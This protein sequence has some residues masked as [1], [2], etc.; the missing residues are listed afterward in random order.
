MVGAV[1]PCKSFIL[2]FNSVIL[3]TCRL[4]HLAREFKKRFNFVPARFVVTFL[5]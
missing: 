3:V 2:W 4:R 1:K 5:K